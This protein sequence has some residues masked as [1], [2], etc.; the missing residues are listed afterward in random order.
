MA[1][2][3]GLGHT[4]RVSLGCAQ[5]LVLTAVHAGA[6][7]NVVAAAAAALLRVLAAAVG[8]NGP[9]LRVAGEVLQA[10]IAAVKPVL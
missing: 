4:A 7:Q 9:M 10:R 2:A 8:A 1:A 5:G 6:S 3:R